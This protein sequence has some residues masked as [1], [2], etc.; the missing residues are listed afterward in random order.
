MNAGRASRTLLDAYLVLFFLYLAAPLLVMMAAAFN[1]YPQ[2]SVTRWQGFTLHWFAALFTD[3]RLG[4]G[5]LH[6]FLVA[7]G[8]IAIAIPCGL[9]GAAILSRLEGK[10]T[11]LLYAVMVSPILTPGLILGLSTLIFWS[12][13]GIGAGLTLATLAQASFITSYCMLMFLARLARYDP[14]LDEAALDLGANPAFVFRRITLPFLWPTVLAAGGI[15][16]LQSFENYNTTVFAIGGDY[17]LPAEI[18]SRMRFGLSPAI[19]A[20]G[21]L[22]VVATVGGAVAWVVLRRR[23]RGG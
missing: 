8:V 5:V 16:F 15:A 7:A 4:T 20:L 1:A 17:T 23:E 9:A 2:P 6:S 13:V 12:P 18:G 14:T 21:V 11:N 3:A 19:A 22:F 10:A